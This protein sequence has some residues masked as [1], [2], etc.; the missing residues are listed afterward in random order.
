LLSVGNHSLSRLSVEKLK[1]IGVT[2]D[3]TLVGKLECMNYLTS[4][5]IISVPKNRIVPGNGSILYFASSVLPCQISGYT[6]RTH[7]LTSA[8]KKAGYDISVFSR[9]GYPNDRRDLE[10]VSSNLLHLDEINYNIIPADGRSNNNLC[11]QFT[12]S[13]NK[14]KSILNKHKPSVVHVASNFENAIPA[15]LAAREIGIPTI[16][17][18]RGFWEYTAASK[19]EGWDTTDQFFFE[20]K[21][22]AIACELSDYVF[23]LTSG[24]VDEIKERTNGSVTPAL[25]PN[26]IDGNAISLNNTTKTRIDKYD[27]NFVIGYIGSI[28]KYEG[29]DD[30]IGILPILKSAIPSVMVVIVGDGDTKKSLESLANELGVSDC[31]DFV[32]RVPADDVDR[33]FKTMDLI[34]LPRKPYK[35]CELVSPL[36]PLEAMLH[37]IPVVAS[38]VKALSDMMVHNET[39]YIFT[40]ANRD[41]LISVLISAY[42]NPKQRQEISKK[43]KAF[44]L[45]ERTW[46][47][48][49]RPLLAIYDK[50]IE[51][52]K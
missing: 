35:V 14:I 40:S 12:E 13:V 2:P 25:L 20:K 52:N 30:L 36:K 31:V 47:Y 48:V 15:I 42:N 9:P 6:T 34:C 49:T 51:E 22:E 41:S 5:S 50:I 28:L 17:E 38:S 26:A 24:M 39:G 8:I 3:D 27:H 43:A 16:Y 7:S 44:V 11:L 1:S 45:R 46:D 37:G 32:G 29:L 4:L 23:T 19:K 21:M 18:V 33:Y 10:S